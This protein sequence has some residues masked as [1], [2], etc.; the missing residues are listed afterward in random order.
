MGH[1]EESQYQINDQCTRSQILRFKKVVAR[2]MK[3]LWPIF[4]FDLSFKK[5]CF[6]SRLLVDFCS[7]LFKQALLR[8]STLLITII[9]KVLPDKFLIL[10]HETRLRKVLIWSNLH[11]LK[12]TRIALLI[13][14][15]NI[16]KSLMAAVPVISENIL[17]FDITKHS[18]RRSAVSGFRY[19]RI[20]LILYNRLEQH[21]ETLSKWIRKFM[22]SSYISPRLQGLLMFKALDQKVCCLGLQVRTYRS[23]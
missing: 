9:W 17:I 6:R 5:Y 12:A 15:C 23:V 18:T 19:G 8:P 13:V 21:L 16:S 22:F 3:R 20:V 11:K 10:L 2:C 1:N 14:F 7:R 4:V